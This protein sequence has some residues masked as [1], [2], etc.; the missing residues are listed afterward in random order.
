MLVGAIPFTSVFIQSGNKKNMSE[1]DLLKRYLDNSLSGKEKNEVE[2]WLLDPENK[3]EIL[4]YLESS[5]ARENGEIPVMPFNELMKKINDLKPAEAKVV[6]FKRK[7][8]WSASAAC[9]LFLLGGVWLGYQFKVTA[10]VA[11]E[12]VMKTA[13]TING[14]YAQLTLSDG[15]EVYLADNSKIS[16][17]KQMNGH[18]VV[19]L[20][21]EAY[22]DVADENKSMTIKTRDLV[23]TAKGSKFNI[24]AFSKDSVVTVTVES[25]KAEVR[26]NNEVFPMLKLRFPENDSANTGKVK[27]KT[28]P[29]TKILPA[30]TV[31]ANEQ[32]VYDKSTN[33][34]DI[35]EIGPKTMPMLNLRPANA[36]RGNSAKKNGPVSPGTLNFYKAD[37]TEVMQKLEDKYGVRVRIETNGKLLPLFS[38]EFS[39]NADIEEVLESV[40]KAMELH[41]QV[42]GN[43]VKL[44][45]VK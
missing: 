21:G 18:S 38:G 27:P 26:K 8:F 1:K 3:G 35:N 29:L 23:T 32:A 43:S 45:V 19:Y 31:R 41:Y 12:W 22:F 17:P 34:T 10:P 4:E 44:T 5:Y 7:L 37:I 30:M 39:E 9:V 33:Q 20:E 11:D 15:S 13:E 14:Q 25:G 16:F 24:S 40:A 36:S 6:S 2:K 42:N 28:L